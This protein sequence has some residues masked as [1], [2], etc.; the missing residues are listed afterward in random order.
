MSCITYAHAFAS[1]LQMAEIERSDLEGCRS[2][3][4]VSSLLCVS[5]FRQRAGRPRKY[6][7]S[8]FSSNKRI[9]LAE[10]TLKKLRAIKSLYGLSS[11]DG[12]V[13]YLIGRHEYLCAMER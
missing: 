3:T 2:T 8:W 11:D 4:D 6:E 1:Q 13:Q 7:G 5:A 10:P 9:Y 12:V